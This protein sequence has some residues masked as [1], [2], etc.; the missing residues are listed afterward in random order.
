MCRNIKTLFNFEPPATD[1]E[2]RAASLQFVRKVSGFSKPSRANREAFEGA[3]DAVA[4]VAAELLATL[5]TEAPPKNREAEAAKAVEAMAQA[6]VA[7][8]GEPLARAHSLPLPPHATA[9]AEA[10]PEPA[11]VSVV[12]RASSGKAATA[13]VRVR[14]PGRPAEVW[15]PA[16][17]ADDGDAALVVA[18]EWL[19]ELTGGKYPAPAVNFER[20]TDETRACVRAI[21]RA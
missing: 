21:H 18:G 7:A 1:D 6:Q 2:I 12:P 20:A 5:T 15:P 14:V 19:R 8:E 16:D 17:A 3:V 11:I 10:T 13:R 9:A 4:Q